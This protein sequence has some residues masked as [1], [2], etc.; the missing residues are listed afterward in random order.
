M[1]ARKKGGRKSAGTINRE[2]Q[3]QLDAIDKPPKKKAARK[4]GVTIWPRYTR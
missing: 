4:S 3:K 2:A 1:T